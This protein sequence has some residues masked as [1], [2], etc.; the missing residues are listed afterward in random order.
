MSFSLPKYD[1]RFCKKG[2]CMVLPNVALQKK[3]GYQTYHQ[4]SGYHGIIFII[5]IYINM[6]VCIYI[7]ITKTNYI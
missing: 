1:I 7:Y 2:V 4:I 6:Y 5:Y 3:S